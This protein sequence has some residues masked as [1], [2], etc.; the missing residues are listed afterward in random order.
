MTDLRPAQPGRRLHS[1]TGLLVFD[2]LECYRDSIQE[3]GALKPVVELVA[4]CRRAEVPIFYARADHRPDGA[5]L[6]TAPTDT[7]KWFR[8]W[9]DQNRPATRPTK[10]ASGSPGA[11][12]IAEISPRP[13]DYDIPKH[14]WSAFFQTHLELSLRTRGISTVLV[15]GGSTHVGVASTVYAGRD[16]DFDMVVVSDCLTGFAEQREFFVEKVFPRMCRVRTS[17]QVIAAFHA[18][19]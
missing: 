10:N 1:S 2:L 12:V 17:E 14:R 19:S 15:V 5:D 13:G 9:T 8:P 4:A 6:A 7:D 3:A 18:T 11:Q 16:L